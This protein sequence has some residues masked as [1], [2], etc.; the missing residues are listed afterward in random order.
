MSLSR[1]LRSVHRTNW[2]KSSDFCLFSARGLGDVRGGGPGNVLA[3]SL[4]L[5]NFK[6]LS[7]TRLCEC[8]LCLACTFHA[9]AVRVV[10]NEDI[11]IP[12]FRLKI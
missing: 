9:P 8:R 3:G 11:K 1:Y 6:K 10:L 7:R 12:G 2:L 5:W 4:I